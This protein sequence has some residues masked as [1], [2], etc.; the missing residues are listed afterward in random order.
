MSL[1]R[2]KKRQP[3]AVA[4][5]FVKNRETVLFRREF[6]QSSSFRGFRRIKLSA[7][8]VDG[9]EQTLSYFRKKD[10]YF[11][12]SKI[13]LECIKIESG[14]DVYFRINVYVDG[15][16]IGRV[17]EASDESISMLTEYEYDKAHIKV[18]ELHRQDGSVMGSN[19]Y[20]FVHYPDVAPVKIN[21][22]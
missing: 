22:E 2:R 9:Y 6:I 21:V 8:H 19:V 5:N 11:K 20:L 10:F 3:E 13:L 16:M 1:F 15:R 17:S 14:S 4:Y 7:S 12:G 18:E